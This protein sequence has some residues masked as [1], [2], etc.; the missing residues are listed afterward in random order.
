MVTCVKWRVRSRR[1]CRTVAVV[2]G[3]FLDFHPEAKLGVQW[4]FR[5]WDSRVYCCVSDA[6][7]PCGVDVV[8]SRPTRGGCAIVFLAGA[9]VE[10]LR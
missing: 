3:Q 4:S 9:A 2:C 8:G 10:R 7:T 5:R 1:G 6:V